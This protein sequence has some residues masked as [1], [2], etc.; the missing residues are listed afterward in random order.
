[1]TTT[2]MMVGAALAAMISAGGM[3]ASAAPA[4]SGHLLQDGR[5]APR[6]R[7]TARVTPS[8]TRPVV[9]CKRVGYPKGCVMR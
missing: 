1:M 3:L 9:Y 2:R 6:L 7:R 4:G 8:S 5:R